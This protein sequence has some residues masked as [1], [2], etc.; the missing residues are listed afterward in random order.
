MNNAVSNVRSHYTAIA[1]AASQC[2]SFSLYKRSCRTR[3]LARV[4][5][6][7]LFC[8]VCGEVTLASQRRS[9]TPLIKKAYHLYFGC[10]LGNQN[11]K[12]APHIVCKSCAIH[13][14]GW[15]NRKGMA[16]PFAVP[17]V[18]REPSNNSSDCYFR[19]TP[20][21]AS[22]MNRKKKQKIDYS[23][24]PSATRPVPHGEHLPMPEPPKDFVLN[25][26][27]EE[28]DTEKTGPHKEPTDP[29]FQGPAFESPHK[30]TK[31]ELNDLVQD[32]SA[33][34]ECFTFHSCCTCIRS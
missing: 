28:E 16:M 33:Q 24:I 12:W 22:G 13:L 8:Y 1:S 20:S 25:L 27:I 9:I 4:N 15:I 6:V 23:N 21:V 19:L 34:W 26:E 5:S 17:M 11:K 3:C 31:D 32:S 30:L 7:D 29:D 2:V 18:W 10:K 14:G